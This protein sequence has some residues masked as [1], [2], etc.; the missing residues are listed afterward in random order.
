ALS[1]SERNRLAKEAKEAKARTEAIA[2][3]IE[4]W[5]RVQ[6]EVKKYNEGKGKWHPGTG[7]VG[8]LGGKWMSQELENLDELFKKGSFDQLMSRAPGMTK[9]FDSNVD[10]KRYE[11][12]QPNISM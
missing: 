5:K 8:A 3:H 12:T 11:D 9:L 6:Q 4:Y 7:W 1:P 10:R 2:D